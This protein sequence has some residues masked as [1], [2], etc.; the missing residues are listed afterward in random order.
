MSTTGWPGYKGGKGKGKGF[1]QFDFDQ[2]TDSYLRPLLLRGVHDTLSERS[3]ELLRSL[4]QSAERQIQMRFY[5]SAKLGEANVIVSSTDDTTA[6]SGGVDGE[7]DDRIVGVAIAHRTAVFSNTVNGCAVIFST[8][9]ERLGQVSSGLP[10]LLKDDERAAKWLY[11]NPI[12]QVSDDLSAAQIIG[13]L[14]VEGNDDRSYDVFTNNV[15]QKG[16]EAISCEVGPYLSV[17][18]SLRQVDRL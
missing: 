9:G 13:I 3:N 7:R 2:V 1:P 6:P 8:A 15:F 5:V 14:G 18:S 4:W 16:V 11:A 10:V 12:R 17:L